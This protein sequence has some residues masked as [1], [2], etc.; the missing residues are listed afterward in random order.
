MKVIWLLRFDFLA[1]LGGQK[2]CLMH[3][4]LSMFI[5]GVIEKLMNMIEAVKIHCVLMKYLKFQIAISRKDTFSNLMRFSALTS[6]Q[7]RPLRFNR[8][9]H[10]C[11]WSL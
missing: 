6:L 10:L 1:K 11:N 7:Q 5:Y 4:A 2:V 9:K 3:G 8:K